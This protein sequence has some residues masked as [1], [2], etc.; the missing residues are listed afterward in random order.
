MALRAALDRHVAGAA[1]EPWHAY[2]RSQADAY[3]E[4]APREAEL[5]AE[6]EARM[7]EMWVVNR[8]R[9]HRWELT[10]SGG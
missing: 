7:A 1:G 5:R 8:P 3:L 6:A 9:A 10:R 2:L 4:H